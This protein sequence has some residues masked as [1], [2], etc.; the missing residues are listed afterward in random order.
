VTNKPFAPFAAPIRSGS[1]VVGVVALIADI[2]FLNDIIAGQKIGNTGYAY[3]IDGSGLIIAHPKA[4]NVFTVDGSKILGMEDLSR[5]MISGERGV[6]SYIYQG[7]AKTAGYAPVQTTGWS[8]GLT[9][10][11]REFLMKANEIRGIILV[12]G[13]M[14]LMLSAFVNA[15]FSRSFTRMLGRALAFAKQAANGDLSSR[16]MA[17]QKDEI[18]MLAHALDEMCEKLKDV[19]REVKRAADKVAQGSVQLSASALDLSQGAT[20]QASAGEEV[21][22]SMEEMVAGIRQNGDSSLETEKIARK[23]AADAMEGGKAV[24]EMVAAM[25]E[26]AAKI[27]IIDEIARQTNLLALNAAIE[28]A[29]AGE[30]GKGF[31]VVASEVRKL[32]ERSQ[33]AAG[34][35]GRL[36]ADSVAIA[37]RA[38]SLLRQVVPDI[39]NTATL[40][41]EIST[42]SREQ[43]VGADQI[44]N[45]M[46][47]LD[48]VIQKNAAGAEELSA[49]AEELSSQAEQLQ[50]TMSWFKLGDEGVEIEGAIART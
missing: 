9:L 15:L 38:G 30:S 27:S 10:P 36:S 25:K 32:A 19:V 50:S 41:Q 22:S 48:K 49:T 42:A 21:S 3:V 26:I 4:A 6:D 33:R 47:Q 12:V 40:V 8:V 31:A 20:E 17:P 37:E 43:N 11:D 44:N 45:A 28:A 18:G 35:I 5:K 29:R 7:E 1:Q 2:S 34:E 13:V 39:G 14:L 24:G 23:A 46:I 16:L